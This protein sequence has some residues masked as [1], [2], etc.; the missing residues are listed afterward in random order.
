MIRERRDGPAVFVMRATKGGCKE[1]KDRKE[2]SEL[3]RE[4]L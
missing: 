1:S 3:H 4:I 2:D